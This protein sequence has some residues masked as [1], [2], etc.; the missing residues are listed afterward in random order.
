MCLK[1]ESEFNWWRNCAANILQWHIG[2]ADSVWGHPRPSIPAETADLELAVLSLKAAASRIYPDELQ[3]PT[4]R[5]YGRLLDIGCGPLSPATVFQAEEIIGVDPLI[6]EYARIGYPL[7]LYSGLYINARTEDLS[8]LFP[9]SMF[10]T[11]VSHNAIDHMDSFLEVAAQVQRLAATNA[12]IR[13]NITYRKAT[14]TEPLELTDRD[15]LAAFDR[16][17]LNRL[18][19][20]QYDDCLVVL[21]GTDSWQ[22]A[23]RNL[24]EG[25]LA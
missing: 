22:P 4:D 21:W 8:K 20:Q 24:T 2:Q 17:P 11:I 5:R 23:T 13:L 9:A 15:V 16:R 12:T 18:R 14:V 7:H 10:D 1:H 25:S 3:M 6:L 19:E